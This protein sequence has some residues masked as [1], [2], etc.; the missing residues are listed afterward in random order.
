MGG[1]CSDEWQGHSRIRATGHGDYPVAIARRGA[2]AGHGAG[3][4]SDHDGPGRA[5][6][7]LTHDTVRCVHRL[8]DLVLQCGLL[9]QRQPVPFDLA[10][11]AAVSNAQ[12]RFALIEQDD[13]VVEAL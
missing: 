4:T 6:N 9:S 3:R 8:A 10:Q 12:A 13:P 7:E 5:A 1:Q 2:K 11:Q